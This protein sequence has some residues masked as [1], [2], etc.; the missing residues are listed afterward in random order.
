[1]AKPF[2]SWP[3]LCR[4]CL[5]PTGGSASIVASAGF[6]DDGGGPTY[7]GV[8]KR[9]TGAAWV[10]AKLMVRVGG[11]WVAKPLRR[12]TGSAWVDV[13]ATGA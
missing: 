12:W 7:S 1:M 13:D 3:R 2:R 4:E 10:K 6:F 5:V 9:W 11:A 8:L